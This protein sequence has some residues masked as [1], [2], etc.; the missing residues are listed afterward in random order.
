MEKTADRIA[1]Y[2]VRTQTVQKD[3]K[4]IYVY[5]FQVGLEFAVTTGTIVISAAII[6]MLIE[7]IIVLAVFFTLRGFT[8]GL[9]MNTFLSCFIC[10]E[11]LLMLTLGAIHFIRL[12]ISVIAV[13][14]ILVL[15]VIKLLSPVEHIN[16]PVF[17]WERKILSRRLNVTIM[18]LMVV[19]SILY[20]THNQY[21]LWVVAAGE[22]LMV[23]LLTAGKIR[24]RRSR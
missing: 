9:H 17:D 13:I 21:G 23:L 7:C 22:L 19:E 6:G 5:G 18:L 24:Y 4:E 16:R 20:F 10:S 14:S 3:K 8:G 11:V 15:A 12:D 1:E 2:L